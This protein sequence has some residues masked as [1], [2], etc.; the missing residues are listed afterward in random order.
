MAESFFS[1]ITNQGKNLEAE[2]KRAGEKII[3]QKFVVGDGAGRPVTP[4]PARSTLVNEVYRGDISALAVSPEQSSQYIAS[5]ALPPDVGGFVVREVGLLTSDGALYSVGSCPAIEKPNNGVSV[6]LQYR[7][8]ISETESITLQVA[9]GDGLFL[10]Q[11]ANLS[12]VQDKNAALVN[13]NGVPKSTLINGHALTGNINVTSQ[14]IFNGQSIGIGAGQDLNNYQTPG[15]YF[16]PTNAGAQSSANYPEAIAGS[17][18]VLKNAGVTQIYYVYNSTRVWIRSKYSSGAWTAWAKSYNTQN[19]PSASEIGALPVNG[20][21]VS[22]T[23][24]QTAR[25]IGGVSFNG[26]ANINLPGVNT[27]GNQNTTGNAATATRLQTARTI[28]GVAFNGTANITITAGQIGAYTK[29]ESDARYI[30]NVR[31]GAVVTVN[32]AGNGGYGALTAPAGHVL[33]AILDMDTSRYP[34]P[35]SPDFAYARPVQKFVNGTWVTV[36]QL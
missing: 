14:D 22:A 9:T 8:A 13:L 15:I 36:S 21:A 5:L 19:K 3:L 31:L 10:R 18:V 35:D 27:Q 29:A 4:D 7:L 16:Q 1:I 17:L 30:Q 12:D 24:L 6:N 20:N 11:D 2:A 25:L 34:M 26:T 23:K 28:N 32:A 33:T